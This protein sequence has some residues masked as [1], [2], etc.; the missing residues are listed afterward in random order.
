MA[1]GIAVGSA[2]SGQLL[3]RIGHPRELGVGALVICAAGLYGLSRVC[4]LGL[5]SQ[6]RVLSGMTSLIALSSVVGIGVSSAIT[7]FTVAVQNKVNRQQLGV[8]TSTLQFARML[9]LALGSTVFGAILHA[10]LSD[11]QVGSAVSDAAMRL[12]DPATLVAVSKLSEVREFY[13]ANPKLGRM[14][15]EADLASSRDILGNAVC[16]VFT[17]AALIGVLGMILGFFAFGKND[18]E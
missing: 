15:Y 8:V 14:A 12:R 17:V 13:L 9:G 1:L 18:S 5:N 2:I 3:S 16:T 6:D 11:R 4:A 7:I 10:S